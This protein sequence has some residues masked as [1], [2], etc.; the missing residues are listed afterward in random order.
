MKIQFKTQRDR[1]LELFS[2]NG[3]FVEEQVLSPA[4]CDELIAAGMKLPGVKAGDFKPAMQP[5]RQDPVFLKG[6]CLPPL[7]DTIARLVGGKPV[8]L[9]TEF[10]YAKPSVRGF[11]N[12]QDNFFV[13]AEP[14]AFASAWMALTDIGPRNGGLIGYPGSH[15]EG[16][17]PVR[18]VAVGDVQDQDPN[19]NN[20]E[21]IL[22]P[23]YQPVDIV[24]PKG[25]VVYLHSHFVHGS[26]PNRSDTYRFVLLCTYLREGVSFRA[27]RYAQREPIALTA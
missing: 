12:H 16:R 4:L 8:G 10:F 18:K 13:E 23:Q 15:K 14:D 20:E 19:A 22:P 3:Y 26:R 24:A 27:G 7:V 2:E 11:S 5:H 21:S 17:L 6:M 9:Q 1:A 25:S